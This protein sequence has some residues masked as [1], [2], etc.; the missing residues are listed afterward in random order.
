MSGS[1]KQD[2]ALMDNVCLVV[3]DAIPASNVCCR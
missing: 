2:L 3:G 1:K